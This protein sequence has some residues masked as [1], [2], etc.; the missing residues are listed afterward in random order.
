MPPF[1]ADLYYDLR[2]RRLLPLV[3]LGIVAIV[4][5][6][7]LLGGG[8]EKE[9]PTAGSGGVAGASRVATPAFTVVESK[10]GVRDYR[11]R[12]ENRSPSDPF[13]QRYQTSGLGS[14]QLKDPGEG[15]NASGGGGETGGEE[16]G[17]TTIETKTGP[18]GGNGQKGGLVFFAWAIDLT[19]KKSVPSGSQAEQQAEGLATP[20]GGATQGA[21]VELASEPETTERQDVLPQTRLPGDKVPVA[22]YMGRS[23]KGL[24]LFLVSSNVK[25]VFGESK[26]VSGDDFCQLLEVARNSRPPSST[27]PNDVRY[28][29]QR[30]EDRAR[31]HRAWL[32]RRA[33][34]AQ[35]FSK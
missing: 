35:S 10:P 4:A 32:S 29:V 6:P 11:K 22:T 7:F 17:G 9:E 27:G 5:V 33:H 24:P 26:C 3:V 15:L 21:P 34:G 8:S 16:V 19:I 30:L 25:S 13:K 14:A 2:E 1:L 12:F 23:K 28:T 20:E 31:R 18:P